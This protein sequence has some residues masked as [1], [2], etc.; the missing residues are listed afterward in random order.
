MKEAYDRLFHMCNELEQS[1]DDEVVGELET[2]RTTC[3]KAFL[4][5]LVGLA[6]KNSKNV[7]MIWLMALHDLDTVHE[8]SW[9]GM[10]LDFLCT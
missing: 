3:I 9:G 1:D 8:W 4:L 2:V 6:N 10:P 7:H 5:L